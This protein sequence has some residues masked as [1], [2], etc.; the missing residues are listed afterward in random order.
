VSF[1]AMADSKTQNANDKRNI[2]RFMIP[3]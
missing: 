3:Q 1:C 2:N